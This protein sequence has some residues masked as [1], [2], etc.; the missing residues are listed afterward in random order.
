MLPCFAHVFYASSR[1]AAAANSLKIIVTTGGDAP[2]Q[3]G[4]CQAGYTRNDDICKAMRHCAGEN[5]VRDSYRLATSG[6]VGNWGALL[7]AVGAAYLR[8]SP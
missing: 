1:P 3:G 6:I 8:H 5:I 4:R 2:K 7:A